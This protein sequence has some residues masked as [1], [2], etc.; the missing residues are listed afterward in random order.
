[1]ILVLLVAKLL[2]KAFGNVRVL[3][4]NNLIFHHA[5]YPIARILAFCYKMLTRIFLKFKVV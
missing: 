5:D 4:F 2:K 1:M 3:D